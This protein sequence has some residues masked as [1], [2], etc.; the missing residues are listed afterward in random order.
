MNTATA[1]DS[2]TYFLLLRDFFPYRTRCHTMKSVVFK[3]FLLLQD[4]LMDIFILFQRN[5][6]G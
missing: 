1:S 5:T 3:E 2:S 6:K 4:D